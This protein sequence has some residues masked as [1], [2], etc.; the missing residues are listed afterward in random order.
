MVVVCGK[1]SLMLLLLLLV[2][3]VLGEEEEVRGERR[4]GLVGLRFWI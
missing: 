2:V 4:G 1:I 3:V